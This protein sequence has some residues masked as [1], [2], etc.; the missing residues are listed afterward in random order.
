M[1]PDVDIRA[2]LIA[3]LRADAALTAQVNRIYDGRPDKATP[4][5]VIV[6]E[7]IGTDWATKDRPGASCASASA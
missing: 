7:G 3:L 4:P 6:G 5:M 2:A 1:N